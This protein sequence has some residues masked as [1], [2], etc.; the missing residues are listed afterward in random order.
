MAKL[1]A[2]TEEQR[3]YIQNVI[4]KYTLDYGV[5]IDNEWI[6]FENYCDTVSNYITFDQMAEIVDYLR[7]DECLIKVERQ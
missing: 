3:N 6:E 2:K 1:Q 5:N 7:G 4:S